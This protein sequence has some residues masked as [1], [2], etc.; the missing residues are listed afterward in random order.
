MGGFPLDPD[1]YWRFSGGRKHEKGE[2]M[3]DTVLLEENDGLAWLTI[4]RPDKLNS[5]NV[6]VFKELLAHVERLETRTEAIGCVVLRGAGRCFSAGHDLGDIAAGEALPK[7]GFQAL[8]IER[9]AGLPQPVIAA[10]H[11][12]CYTGALEL[13]LAADVI[14]ASSDAK[15]A[16]T[17]AKWSLTPVWGMSQRL[18]RRVGASKAYEMMLTTRTYSGEEA[19]VLGLANQCLPAEDFWGSVEAF[20]RQVLANSWFSHRANKRLLRDTDGLPLAAGIAHEIYRTEGRGPDMQ[21]RIAA[22]AK[23]KG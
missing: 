12:H 11:S 18:P 9:L 3:G 7:P 5:L 10:V 6:E 13:A 20:A 8:V 21:E 22:F 23:R 1:R 2:A 16:D 4:N 14:L 15:F 17:H 19:A